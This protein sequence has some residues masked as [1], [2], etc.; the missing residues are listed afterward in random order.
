[1]TAIKRQKAIGVIYSSHFVDA[2][3]LWLATDSHA[4]AKE[5]Q[6]ERYCGNARRDGESG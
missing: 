2:M 6:T 5:I 1:M 4:S 3:C